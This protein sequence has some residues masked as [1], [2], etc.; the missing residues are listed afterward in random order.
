MTAARLRRLALLA[1][2]LSTAALAPPAHA[3]PARQA[4]ADLL[5]GGGS[6]QWGRSRHSTPGASPLDLALLPPGTCADW[7]SPGPEPELPRGIPTPTLVLAGQFDPNIGPEQS[8][9]VAAQIG[10]RT[11][12]ILFP[13]LGHNVRH[14]SPCARTLVAAFID[15]PAREPDAACA[16]EPYWPAR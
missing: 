8:R 3:A 4:I 11:R 9:R 10:P 14:F 6:R 7:S 15:D 5:A 2:I 12:W 13:G 16:G 1:G